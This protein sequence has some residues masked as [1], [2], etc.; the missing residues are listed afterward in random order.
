MEQSLEQ[1]A[2]RNKEM[3]VESSVKATATANERSDTKF[4]EVGNNK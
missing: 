2:A 4:E 3:Q 1:P